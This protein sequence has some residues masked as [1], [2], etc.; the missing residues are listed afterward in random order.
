MPRLPMT[1]HREALG[2]PGAGGLVSLEMA[3][4]LDSMREWGDAILL[5]AQAL[6]GQRGPWLTYDRTARAEEAPSW[7]ADR[8][9]MKAL[10]R[11][12]LVVMVDD[13]AR[14]IAA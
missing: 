9:C 4:M 10:Q 11:R 6:H 5:G 7:T 2:V 12:G 3:A 14:A 8:S 13:Y 1:T